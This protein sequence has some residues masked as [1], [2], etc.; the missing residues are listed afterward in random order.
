MQLNAEIGKTMDS[1]WMLNKLL[2]CYQQILGS[3]GYYKCYGLFCGERHAKHTSL[4]DNCVSPLVSP[5][6]S[7]A[8]T[9]DCWTS[10]AGQ[11]CIGIA[12]H[13]V[14]KVFQLKY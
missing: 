13:F 10:R 5:A 2:Q 8:F 14:G 4:R 1:Q 3:S 9:I 12:V 6:N 11:P 7:F